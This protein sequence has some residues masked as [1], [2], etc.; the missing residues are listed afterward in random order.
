MIVFSLGSRL[1]VAHLHYST[2]F[3]AD[4]ALF[5]FRATPYSC[6]VVIY[7]IAELC[8]LCGEMVNFDE[9]FVK[10]SRNTPSTF[11]RFSEKTFGCYELGRGWVYLG[12]PMEVDGRFFV[13]LYIFSR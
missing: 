11:V 2:Y 10:F 9:S 6:Q 7:F 1:V 3:F 4:D 5:F 8:T 13:C 12:C